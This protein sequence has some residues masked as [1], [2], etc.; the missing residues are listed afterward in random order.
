MIRLIFSFIFKHL[1]LIVILFGSGSFF[2]GNILLKETVSPI[3]YGYYSLIITYFSLLYVFGLLGF[4][5][6]FLRKSECKE[7]RVIITQKLQ[8]KSIVVIGLSTTILSISLFKYLYPEIIVNKAILYIASICM[9]FSLFIFN[10]LRLSSQF[11]LA[12]LLS[13]G[14]KIVGLIM[15]ILMYANNILEI[16]LYIKLLMTVIILFFIIIL[17]LSLKKIKFSFDSQVNR[18]EIILYGFHFLISIVSFS[19][20][21]FG[22]R[23]FIQQKFGITEFGDYFYLNNFF[24]GPFSILQSYVGFKQIVKFKFSISAKQ[25]YRYNKKILIFGILL[26]LS[27]VTISELLKYTKI[28]S[29]N[30]HAHIPIIILLIILGIVKLLNALIISAFGARADL[31]SLETT[32]VVF[33]IFT[34]I[35][36]LFGWFLPFN[37]EFVVTLFI[38]IWLARNFLYQH[39][40]FLQLRKEKL[41]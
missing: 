41:K 24:L 14:W 33:I 3:Q 23:F 35:I 32:N 19:L 29:F 11:F 18:K 34:I 12:Q 40:L 17:S 21:T 9:I 7:Q 2:I 37:I 6:V 22:D 16:S 36:L 15:I 10:L 28:V 39:I 13:N 25:Y 5:Q 38:I 26:G 4:E 8:I 31:K 1:S 27:M 30:F 20:I